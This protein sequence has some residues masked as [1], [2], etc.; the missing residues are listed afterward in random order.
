MTPE[1]RRRAPTDLPAAPGV[2]LFRD[3]AGDI[4][5]VGKAKSLRARVRWYYGR[6]AEKSTKL[7]ELL[8]RLE[9]VETIV[10]STESEALLLENTLIKEHA[11][12]FNI[13]LRDDKSFPY[14]KVTVN[15]RFPR[16]LVTRDLRP[17]GARYFGPFTAVGVMRR[18]LRAIRQMYTVR[19]CHFDLPD[20]APD[21][22]CLDYHI[23]RCRAPCVG[24]QSE[25][26]YRAMIDEILAI[27][28]GRTRGLKARLRSRMKDAVDGLRFEEAAEL[29]DVIV[30]LE[31]L[32]RRQAAVDVR[33][34]DRDVLAV[35][36]REDGAG[37]VAVLLRVRDGHLLGR[38]VRRLRTV[39]GSDGSEVTAAVVKSLYVRREE[40]PP[41]L[42]VED[43][44][45]DRRLLERMLTDRWG[46]AFRIR[47]PQRG[48]KRRLVELAR[49]NARQLLEEDRVS[50]D[51]GP[52]GESDLPAA[53]AGLARV[54]GLPDPPRSLLC[55][56][57]STLGGSDSVGSA[58]WLRDGRPDRSEYRRFRIRGSDGD[59]DDYAMMQEIVSRYFHRRV[60]EG[61]R[62]PDLVVIDGGRGQLGAAR[63]AMES[64]GVSDLP[65]VA[66]AKR[67]EEI[68]PS[69]AA[70]AAVRLPRRDP[71]LHWLQRARDEAHR[72]AVGYNRTLRR[73]RTLRSRLADVPGV[74]PGRE[75]ELLR[76]FGSVRAI[77]RLSAEELCAVPGIGPALAERIRAAL[78]SGPAS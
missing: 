50:P 39:D 24:Y 27:L 5:Y 36:R 62:L 61:G 7:K 58:A 25:Q 20:G 74:G 69:E 54:L 15:E 22:P 2:Y 12:P 41:E 60:A 18:T 59:P 48:A 49:R 55:F 76:R 23:D 73:R 11:P 8:R 64:A 28:A 31:V 53:A 47:V 71:A 32:E 35:A 37:A 3:A 21:R 40:L 4:L 70:S 77:G 38:E 29:R 65:V 66:L 19:T 14:V 33:G 68:F 44:F 16:I 6:D 72:F 75:A 56:D 46:R 9:S 1:P 42:L 57:V 67:E 10:V 52:A 45:P 63:Q 34:G 17:D 43:D 30:G 13:Q 78:E 51:A 26:E